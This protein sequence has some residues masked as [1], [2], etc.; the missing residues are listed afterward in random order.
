MVCQCFI[1]PGEL[2]FFIDQNVF[3]G[4]Q[5]RRV[6]VGECLIAVPA[7]GVDQGR[8]YHAEEAGQQ[9][10][11]VGRVERFGHQVFECVVTGRAEGRRL[12]LTQALVEMLHVLGIFPK[13]APHSEFP[14]H[15]GRTGQPGGQNA[16]G[17]IFDKAIAVEQL[18]VV[19]EV[20]LLRRGE[21]LHHPPPYSISRS[22]A[23]FP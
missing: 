16:Q 17:L 20:D 3:E 7:I 5:G 22:A 14:V 10:G 12:D 2:Q 15:V 11:F 13:Q 18:L 23:A 4:I 9:V 21:Y 6:G 1:C 8:F 19:S